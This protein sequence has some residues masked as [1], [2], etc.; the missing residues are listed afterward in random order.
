[1]DDL[2]R[3]ILDALQNDFPIEADPYS[4]IAGKLGIE[5]EVLWQRICALLGD[6][7]IR[8]I[9]ASLNS[10]KMGFPSTLCAAAAPAE[11]IEPLT[12]VSRS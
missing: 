5:T 12:T 7:T 3:R 9:G 11:K 8:R 1:M 4:I 6:G 10:R 2:D